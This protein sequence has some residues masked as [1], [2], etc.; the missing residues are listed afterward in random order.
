VR[1][2][3]LAALCRMNPGNV[4]RVLG[5]LFDRG[6]VEREG[7]AYLT[8][9]PGSLLEAWAEDG[10]RAGR[11]RVVLPVRGRLDGEVLRL[12]DVID[13]H[14]VVSG[15]LAAELQAAYLPAAHAIVHCVD[16]D[17]MGSVRALADEIEPRPLRSQSQIIIDSPTRAS[18]T[19]ARSGIVSRSSLPH[20]ST[21]TCS[22]IAV[23]PE[24]PRSMCDARCSATD[25][26]SHAQRDRTGGEARG[27]GTWR[28]RP[29]AARASRSRASGRRSDGANMAPSPPRGGHPTEGDGGHRPRHRPS[30]LRLT[31]SSR[32]IRPLLEMR[33]YTPLRATRDSASGRNS[34]VTR[35]SSMSSSPRVPHARSR[36]CSRETLSPSRLLVWPM[37]SCAA[38]SSSISSSSMGE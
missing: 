30:G 12:L 29:G 28:S 9:D 1:L 2:S 34:E 4:H 5:A 25:A 37:R 3:E 13:G 16:A 7:G 24:R 15:E 36:L 32:R 27:R 38:H 17:A 31:A 23:A 35:F 19:S 26:P 18:P 14:G 10:P 8:Q 21:S 22:E 11:D 20:S 33:G 6:F